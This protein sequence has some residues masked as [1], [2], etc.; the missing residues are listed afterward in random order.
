VL[1]TIKITR[2]RVLVPK[3]GSMK[4]TDIPTSAMP[5]PETVAIASGKIV[6]SQ[7]SP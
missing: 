1:R 2:A 4:G 3:D 7:K 6:T 5:N